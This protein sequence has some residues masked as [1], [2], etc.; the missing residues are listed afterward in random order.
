MKKEGLTTGHRIPGPL[1]SPVLQ[2]LHSGS[3]YGTHKILPN[4]LIQHIFSPPYH[5]QS[6]GQAE[7]FVDTFK[8]AL[9][10]RKCEDLPSD[11]SLNTKSDS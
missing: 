9:A 5:P 4:H 7:R 11:V 6:N 2:Q 1:Q 8:R 3:W 10:I